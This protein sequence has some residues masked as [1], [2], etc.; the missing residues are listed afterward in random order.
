MTR[1]EQIAADDRRREEL[2]CVRLD[3]PLTDSEREEE[4]RLEMRL[5][6][7]VWRAQQREAERRLKEAA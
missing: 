4:Q 5:Q 1:L 7:R 6:M 2:S 3:R